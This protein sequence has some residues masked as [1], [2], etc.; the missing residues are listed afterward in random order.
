MYSITFAKIV[1][2]SQTGFA[3]LKLV[4]IG[5]AMG[6]VPVAGFSPYAGSGSAPHMHNIL[7]SPAGALTVDR[8]EEE[9]RNSSS[10]Q[11]LQQRWVGLYIIMCGLEVGLKIS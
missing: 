11:P 6:A 4:Y 3:S 1:F 8:I 2:L 5:L 9:Q 7:R 10:P